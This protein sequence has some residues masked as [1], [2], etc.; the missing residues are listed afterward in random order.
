MKMPRTVYWNGIYLLLGIF[1]VERGVCHPRHLKA[2]QTA[3]LSVSCFEGGAFK[4][5][6]TNNGS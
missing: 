6:L 5:F 4:S 2:G 3:L 1:Y